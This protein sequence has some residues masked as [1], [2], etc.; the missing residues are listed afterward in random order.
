MGPE[1]LE[2]TRPL[3]CQSG[4]AAET[5]PVQTLAGFADVAAMVRLSAPADLVEVGDIAAPDG[6]EGVE[7]AVVPTAAADSRPKVLDNKTHGILKSARDSRR[8]VPNHYSISNSAGH[9]RPSVPG[10]RRIPDHAGW[11]APIL[12]FETLASHPAAVYTERIRPIQSTSSIHQLNY[13]PDLDSES[14]A[15]Y[16]AAVHFERIRSIQST[17]LTCRLDCGPVLHQDSSRVD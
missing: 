13:G 9:L 4:V 8:R 14:L 10:N 7:I 2:G 1:V 16:S 3:G 12:E 5:A 17:S 15:S 11:K 6:I